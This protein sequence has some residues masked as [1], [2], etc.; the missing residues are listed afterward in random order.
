MLD[1][2]LAIL[3]HILAFGLVSILVAEAVLVRPG[4]TA[5]DARRV[6]RL[7]LGYG[8]SAVLLLIVGVG[9]LAFAAKGWA[10]YQDNP[11]FWAKMASFLA[12]GLLSVPPTLRYFAWVGLTKV[13]ADRAPTEGEVAGVRRWLRAEQA[14]IVL[15]LIFAAAMARYGHG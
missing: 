6:A 8:V 9:R 14:G 5:L 13:E 2:I 15:I 4:M 7:D 1:L 10:W 11:W 12:V 3:H